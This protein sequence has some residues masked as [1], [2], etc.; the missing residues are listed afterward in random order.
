[1]F[2]IKT[3]PSQDLRKVSCLWKLKRR[4]LRDR[5]QLLSPPLGGIMYLFKN[6]RR[7][8][9]LKQK[10]ILQLRERVQVLF[11]KTLRSHLCSTKASLRIWVFH[12]MFLTK[13]LEIQQP[14][15]LFRNDHYLI[16][17]QRDRKW[18]QQSFFERVFR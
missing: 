1:M 16:K 8:V 10:K 17:Y 12:Q 7:R 14:C 18:S 4:P 3:I 9:R 2:E 6:L 15:R 5:I 13:L 11:V